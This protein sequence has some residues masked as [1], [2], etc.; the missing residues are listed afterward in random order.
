LKP[1]AGKSDLIA[2]AKVKRVFDPPGYWSGTFAAMQAVEYEVVA[3][4][5]GKIKKPSL[6][7]SHSVVY[8]SVTADREKP[9]LAPDLFKPGQE[10]ILLLEK[11]PGKFWNESMACASLENQMCALIASDEKKEAAKR[12]KSVPQPEYSAPNENCGVLVNNEENR[13]LIKYLLGAK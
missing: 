13:K 5:K 1:L 2:V 10:L 8:N 11:G 12:V 7:A 3:V 4:L 9:Q 6:V